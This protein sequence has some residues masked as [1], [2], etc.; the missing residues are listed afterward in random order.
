VLVSHPKKTRYIAEARIKTDRVDSRAL[1]EL[2][3]LNLLPE[4]YVPP[5][6]IA[7]LR[8]KVR[9]RAF[10]VRQQTKLQVRRTLTYEGVKPP[11]EYGLF[12]RKGVDWLKGLGLEPIDSYLRLMP[13]LK[14]EI[15]VLSLQLRGSGPVHLQQRRRHPP[16]THHQGGLGVAQVGDGGGGS[17]P[18]E[19]RHAGDPG[20]PPDCRAPGQEVGEG[21]GSQDAPRGLSVCVEEQAALLRPR[22]RS[23]VENSSW[24]RCPP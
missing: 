3:R 1:A 20:L 8:E 10:L 21:G 13:P 24:Q 14:E 4:S 18:P 23:G 5:L 6:Y 17:H 12:T 2:L 22:S 19:V 15:R 16:L 11:K 7:E 9:R